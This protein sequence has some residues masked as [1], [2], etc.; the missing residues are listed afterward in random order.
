M[1]L[2]LP[3]SLAGTNHFLLLLKTISSFYGKKIHHASYRNRPVFDLKILEWIQR[4]L[5]PK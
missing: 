1:V 2:S 5:Y 4:V 3:A